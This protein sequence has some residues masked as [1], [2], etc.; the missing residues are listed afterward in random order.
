MRGAVNH[1]EARI[2]C[3]ESRKGFWKVRS[4]VMNQTKASD[5]SKERRIE[6]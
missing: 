4:K 6:V 2:F 1:C 3:V 5:P